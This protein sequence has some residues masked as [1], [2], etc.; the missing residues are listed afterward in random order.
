M[1][2]Y[3]DQ[4]GNWQK[5]EEG[6]S[7][8]VE[9][10]LIELLKN[11]N[12]DQD[13]STY[14]EEAISYLLMTGESFTKGD[15]IVGTDL[16]SSFYIVPSNYVEVV[17]D[18]KSF[19]VTPESYVVQNPNS[20]LT[21]EAVEKENMMFI[22]YQNPTIVGNETARGMSPLQAGYLS[23]MASNEVNVA[24]SEILKNKGA[25]GS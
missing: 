19:P 15:E 11:P 16:F 8:P 10:R 23:L 22:K 21:G 17:D 14:L 6:G 3:I 24:N 25:T 18:I 2:Q 7:D 20:S 4:D 1:L 12:E 5:L 9:Q 13:F